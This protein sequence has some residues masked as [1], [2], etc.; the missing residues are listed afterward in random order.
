MLNSPLT[1]KRTLSDGRKL[2]V[3]TLAENK[4]GTYFQYDV[5]YLQ[6][7]TT[8]LAPFNLKADLSLQKAPKHPHYGLHGVFADSLPDG[9]G[10]YLMDR[11]FRKHGYNPHLIT[12]LERLAY[13]GEQ[14]LGALS[15]EPE[16][17]LAEP[18]I[19]DINLM[20]LGKEAIQEFEGTESHLIEH[21]MHAG[22][23]GGARP[24]MNVTQ[25]SDGCYSTH[26][27][28]LG[29]KLIVKLTSEKFALKHAESLVE[30]TYMTMAKNLGIEVPEFTLIDAGE[31]QFWLQQTRFDCTEKGR[32]H[33]I[34]ACGL[35]DASFREP[36][37]DYVDLIKA[38]RLLCNLD[39]ARKMLK[40][41]LF[42]FIT[43][44]QDDHAKNFAFLADDSDQWRLSPFYDVVYSP[45]PYREHMTSFLGDGKNP[46]KALQ[47]MA[48]QAGYSSVKP[49]QDM[50]E[51]IYTETQNF[52]TQA[53]NLGLSE[54]LIKEIA[55]QMDIRW[56]QLQ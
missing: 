38:T 9:W 35:L 2:T 1:V 36:S 8:S 56:K 41:A 33:M 21:L 55:Q 40:R 37:L 46:V 11:V 42:N 14:C 30:F 31:G 25:C 45:S 20:T 6:R 22:G 49:L 51:E 29:K 50:L 27:D 47:Q 28:A 23:S 44:N 4:S 12:A 32:Y 52:Q 15:Y 54:T 3:G 16:I 10:L 39:E 17:T 34:S 5:D 24:K 13:I 18:D 26:P 43:V 19:A 7:H 53:R 48:G